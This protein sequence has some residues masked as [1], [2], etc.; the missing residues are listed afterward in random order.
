MNKKIL[1]SIILILVISL[2]FAAQI[3]NLT[4]ITHTDGIKNI[5]KNILAE[6]CSQDQL[7]YID[8]HFQAAYYYQYKPYEVNVYYLLNNIVDEVNVKFISFSFS[9]ATLT[10]SLAYPGYVAY[11]TTDDFQQ[12]SKKSDGS[13]DM[14]V[15]F[16]ENS[17]GASIAYFFIRNGGWKFIS[18]VPF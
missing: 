3:G 5:V 8:T 10:M 18:T 16:A 17:S 4:V 14:L 12:N 11:G 7:D 13:L 2:T 6:T 15:V 9:Y 1:V